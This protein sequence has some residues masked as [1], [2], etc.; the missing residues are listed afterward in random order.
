MDECRGKWFS[1]IIRTKFQLV[2]FLIGN[3][4]VVWV[5]PL[6]PPFPK[7]GNN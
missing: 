7:G 6:N 2:K 3:L 4:S 1:F 5:I